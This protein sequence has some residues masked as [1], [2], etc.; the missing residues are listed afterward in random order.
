[1]STEVNSSFYAVIKEILKFEVLLVTLKNELNFSG[2]TQF[3]EKCWQR[4]VLNLKTAQVDSKGLSIK[5]IILEEMWAYH[6]MVCLLDL[7]GWGQ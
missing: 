1:M 2:G 5:P 4:L 3:L 7:L 6:K